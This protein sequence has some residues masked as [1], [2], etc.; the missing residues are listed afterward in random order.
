MYSEMPPG[1]YFNH[2]QWC[3]SDQQWR[4]PA[5]LNMHQTGRTVCTWQLIGPRASQRAVKVSYSICIIPNGSFVADQRRAGRRFMPVQCSIPVRTGPYLVWPR[6]TRYEINM[7]NMT[8]CE[9][10]MI[11]SF[12]GTVS[13]NA[14]IA[15]S[16]VVSIVPSFTSLHTAQ[17]N[18]AHIS[19][20]TY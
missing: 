17:C 2:P 15:T 7:K 19:A 11:P 5:Y 13:C 6:M 1:M 16:H 10:N 20:R 18:T 4:M 14:S 3:C 9:M 8:R 12:L